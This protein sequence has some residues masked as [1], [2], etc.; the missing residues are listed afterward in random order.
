MALL[1]KEKFSV[2]VVFIREERTLD[3][4]KVVN[5][6]FSSKTRFFVQGEFFGKVEFSCRKVP[7]KEDF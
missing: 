2:R 3:K 6:E 1:V 5:E 7:S 4:K